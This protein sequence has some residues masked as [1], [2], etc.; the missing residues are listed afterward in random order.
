MTCFAAS[1]GVPFP[2]AFTRMEWQPSVMA[3]S[4][5]FLCF[6]MVLMRSSFE[7]API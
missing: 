4:T 7:G 5:H 1:N 3:A 2:Y 6:S